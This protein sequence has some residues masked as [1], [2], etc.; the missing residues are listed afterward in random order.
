VL[1]V[2][3]KNQT[4]IVAYHTL[5]GNGLKLLIIGLGFL[6]SLDES[7]VTHTATQTTK[8]TIKI[9]THQRATV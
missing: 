6:S 4:T 9:L 7:L 8:T 2:A 5:E 1:I 3:S